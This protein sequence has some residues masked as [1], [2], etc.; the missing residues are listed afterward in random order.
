[1]AYTYSPYEYETRTGVQG[2]PHYNQYEG[3]WQTPNNSATLQT[4][5][6]WDIEEANRQRSQFLDYTGC[7]FKG[8]FDIVNQL[9]SQPNALSKFAAA[10]RYNPYGG[11]R[12]DFTAPSY[13]G[14]GMADDGSET[15]WQTFPGSFDQQGYLDAR[16]G[17]ITDYLGKLGAFLGNMGMGGSDAGVAVAQAAAQRAINRANMPTIGMSQPMGTPQMGS[18]P[19]SPGLSGFGGGAGRLVGKGWG[20]HPAFK[21]LLSGGSGE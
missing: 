18:N 10:P 17:N 21:G 3:E 8:L 14:W 20:S 7:Q 6:E 2:R 16:F 15:N 13:Q 19:A 9:D 4:A 12:A 1:M 11:T 5:S